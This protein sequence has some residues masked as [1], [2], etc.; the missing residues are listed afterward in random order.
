ME[1]SFPGGLTAAEPPRG[2]G[3]Q[4]AP[5]GPRAAPEPAPWC[6]PSQAWRAEGSPWPPGSELC[7]LPLGRL[8]HI[9]AAG[10]G[11]NRAQLARMEG[12]ACLLLARER[13]RNPV[14]GTALGPSLGGNPGRA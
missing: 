2:R 11:P 9:H 5:A 1:G 3:A 10:P 4:A 14:L 13:R 7:P 12:N 6:R 8:R